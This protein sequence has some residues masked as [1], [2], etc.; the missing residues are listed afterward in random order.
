MH[1]CSNFPVQFTCSTRPFPY[2]KATT[3]ASEPLEVEGGPSAIRPSGQ[4]LVSVVAEVV[5]ARASVPQELLLHFV[6]A[7]GG[8]V[9]KAAALY[10]AVA[11]EFVELRDM[12]R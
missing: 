6:R 10:R 12:A 1:D 8:D 9:S 11:D 5:G 2:F 7:G 4:R 3:S